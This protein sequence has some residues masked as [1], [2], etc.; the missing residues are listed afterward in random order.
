[1][2]VAIA[3]AGSWKGFHIDSLDL[4]REKLDFVSANQLKG[5]YLWE[6][7]LHDICT[8]ES[9]GG[10]LLEAVASQIPARRGEKRTL[11]HIIISN[12]LQ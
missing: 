6:V 10:I 4:I 12:T 1:M 2:A 7:G 8:D 3:R 9:P 11:I 5:V